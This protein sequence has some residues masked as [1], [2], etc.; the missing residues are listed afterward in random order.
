[1]PKIHNHYVPKFYLKGFTDEQN[2]DKVYVY[3]KG[4]NEA[5]QTQVKSIGNEL[6]LY[7]DELET[8]LAND[9]ENATNPILQ[10]L[11]DF[12]NITTDEKYTLSR[13]MITMRLRVP[14]LRNW[15]IE[16]SPKFLDETFYSIEGQLRDLAAR[17]P[18]KTDLVEQRIQDLRD[19]RVNKADE[20]VREV[21]LKNIPVSMD[22]RTVQTLAKMEWRFMHYEGEQFFLTSDNPLFYFESIGIGNEKSEVTFP[23]AKNLV[24][25]AK[26]QMN[27]PPGFHRARTQFVKGVNRRT[28]SSAM[29]YIFSPIATDWIP[30]LLNK[31]NIQLSRFL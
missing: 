13:Y 29:K 17:H 18:D 3:E 22:K 11:R 31:G 8:V 24:L 7:T 21:W 15:L 2:S 30:Y 12:Q 28:I 10:K 9:I 16:K 19:M 6:G 23:L 1:M 20:L 4:K 5:F 27:I 25:W 26:W 14:K